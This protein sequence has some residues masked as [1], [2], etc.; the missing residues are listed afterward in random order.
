[1][2]CRAHLERVQH[3][4]D[5]GPNDTEVDEDPTHPGQPQHRQQHQ[6]GLG[7]GPVRK[8]SSGLPGHISKHPFLSQQQFGGVLVVDTSLS[9]G[10][11]G[12]ETAKP[13]LALKTL[14]RVSP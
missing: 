12:K 9:P 3:D 5:I 7:Y 11:P 10:C 1:M 2:R 4:E 14:P 6:D 13:W 8:N